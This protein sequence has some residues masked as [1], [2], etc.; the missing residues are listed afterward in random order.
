[1]D[2]INAS[3][4]SSYSQEQRVPEQQASNQNLSSDAISQ[5]QPSATEHSSI[6]S[7]QFETE[8][9]KISRFK[10][11][12]KAL[13]NSAPAQF[14]HALL[15]HKSEMDTDIKFRLFFEGAIFTTQFDLKDRIHGSVSDKLDKALNRSETPQSKTE[16]TSLEK[17]KKVAGNFGKRAILGIAGRVLTA[18][19]TPLEVIRSAVLIPKRIGK[20]IQWKHLSNQGLTKTKVTHSMVFKQLTKIVLAPFIAIAKGIALTA[21]GVDGSVA[22]TSKFSQTASLFRKLD[23]TH[24]PSERLEQMSHQQTESSE[25]KQ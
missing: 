3:L 22:P 10:Q 8:E 15:F 7:N 25:N 20:T 24:I 21:V 23:I 19:A 1:M 12:F 5:E 16:L 11:G 2:P 13:K 9:K 6:A 4:P 17:V 18:V 14:L